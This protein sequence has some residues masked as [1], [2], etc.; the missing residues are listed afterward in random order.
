MMPQPA[1]SASPQKGFSGD[2]PGRFEALVFISSC[3]G[4][5]SRPAGF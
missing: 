3:S 2:L 1:A 5:R 4:G